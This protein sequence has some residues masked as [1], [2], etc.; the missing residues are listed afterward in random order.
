MFGERYASSSGK[1][2]TSKDT[3]PHPAGIPMETVMASDTSCFVGCSSKGIRS[4]LLF[5]EE[6]S[7]RPQITTPSKLAKSVN[8]PEAK[9]ERLAY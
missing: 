9:L 4:A 3:D 2:A 5:K 7:R 1:S 8:H 6:K